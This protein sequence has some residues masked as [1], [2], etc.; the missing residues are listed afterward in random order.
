MNRTIQKFIGK[1]VT[2][3][4]CALFERPLK[5]ELVECDDTF[6]IIEHSKMGEVVI[7]LTA[8]SFV[9]AATGGDM[10]E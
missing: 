2:V 3:L 7:P 6:I 9:Y 5:G 8:V 4:L 1:Q 10:E